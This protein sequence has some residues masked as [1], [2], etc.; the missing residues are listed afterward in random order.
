LT[1][2][3][4]SRDMLTGSIAFTQRQ[5]TPMSSPKEDEPMDIDYTRDLGDLSVIASRG[6]SPQVR[7]TPRSPVRAGIGISPRCYI[8]SN[9]N[10]RATPSP[11]RQSTLL[12]LKQVPRKDGFAGANR[13]QDATKKPMAKRELRTSVSTSVLPRL[14]QQQQQQQQST[15]AVVGIPPLPPSLTTGPQPQ[16]PSSFRPT[17]QRNNPVPK[18]SSDAISNYMQPTASSNL[19]NGADRRNKATEALKSGLKKT[20]GLKRS[21]SSVTRTNK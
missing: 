21:M 7:S 2:G 6:K 10:R 13:N 18:D 16:P 14:G 11:L 4:A 9:T 19:K 15:A 20:T 5:R 17:L 8:P 12:D 1:I 3:V